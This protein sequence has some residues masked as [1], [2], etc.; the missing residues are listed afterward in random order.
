MGF[1]VLLPLLQ[2]Q[3]ASA[4]SDSSPP[5]PCLSCHGKQLKGH[6]KLGSGNEACWVCHFANEM[7]KLHLEGGAP[8]AL[9][10]STQICAQCHQT[11]YQ[12][13]NDGTHGAPVGQR[14]QTAIL[15]DGKAKCSS[16]HDPHEPQINLLNITEPHQAAIAPP[17][18]LPGAALLA[19]IGIS[20]LYIFVIVG[21]VLKKRQVP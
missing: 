14:E 1:G 4:V 16:C 20:L 3:P 2:T 9:S 15:T 18:R 19:I 21:I 8:L 7:G 17:P 11:V 6:D 13:W 10:G 12:S 5:L